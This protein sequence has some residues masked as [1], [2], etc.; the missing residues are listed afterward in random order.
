MPKKPSK[1]LREWCIE[2]HREDL[3]EEW[4]YEKNGEL[5]YTPDNISKGAN[6]DVHW[7]C[8]N[9]HRWHTKL[10]SR[11]KKGGTNCPDCY[12]NRLFVGSNDFETWCKSNNREDLL[13]EWDYKNNTLLPSEITP[14]SRKVKIHWKCNKGHTWATYPCVRINGSGCPECNDN[15]TSF[16]EQAIL[17]YILQVFPNAIHRCK[18]LGFELDIYIP[19]LKTGIEYD[20]KYFH[21]KNGNK[22]EIKKN[23]L[24]KE[25]GIKLIRIRENGLCNYEDCICIFRKDEYS[26][27]SLDDVLKNLFTCLVE[28]KININ[29]IKDR[30]VILEQYKTIKFKNSLAYKFPEIAK[31]WHPTKNGNLKPDQFNYGC[32]DKVW[33]I[34]EKGHEWQAIISSR[35]KKNGNNCPYCSGQMVW[36]GD[37]DFET[38]CKDHKL[39]CL[40][41]EWDY[42]KNTKNPNEYTWCSGQKVWWKCKNNHSYSAPI[43]RRINGTNCERCYGRKKKVKCIETNKVFESGADAAKFCGLSRGDCIYQCCRGERKTA[44]GYHWEYI[45]EENNQGKEEK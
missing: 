42:D 20:G 32:D 37:N 19:S 43:S 9:N 6:K 39:T 14:Q 5:G 31:E 11:T 34:C 40:L 45:D 18:D 15:K 38:Y 27:E 33:W 7:K 1:T 12:G 16:P 26:Y 3:L 28:T 36:K 35:T 41:E 17:Y 13:N 21:K 4:D 30:I 25:N 10:Y 29:T 8:K 44:G 24:C 2:N 23:V 22:N